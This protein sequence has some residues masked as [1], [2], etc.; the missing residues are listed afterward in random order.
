MRRARH[1]HRE[2]HERD[3]EQ[4]RGKVP[5]PCR[6]LG[7]NAF[8]QLHVGEPQHPTVPGQLNEDVERD[9][10]E[11]DQQEQEEPSVLEPRERYRSK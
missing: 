2:E 8:Q 7:R 1:R 5:P 6:P 4:D 3:H 9:D 10:A 11:H